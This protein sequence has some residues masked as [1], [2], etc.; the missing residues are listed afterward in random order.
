MSWWRDV[1]P[2]EGKSEL[3]EAL[4]REPPEPPRI[5][6]LDRLEREIYM[7]AARAFDHHYRLRPVVR[8]IALGRLER[9]GLRL[10]SGSDAVREVLGEELWELARPDREPPVDRHGPGPG[11]ADVRETIEQLERL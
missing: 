11:L 4:D 5:A 8:E 1:A 7:G 6:E 9:R 10:D 3:E 2:L